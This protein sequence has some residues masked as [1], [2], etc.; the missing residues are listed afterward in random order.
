MPG[1]VTVYISLGHDWSKYIE[2]VVKDLEGDITDDAIKR[3]ENE[4]RRKITE[5]IP[6]DL[7]KSP[8]MEGEFEARQYDIVQSSITIEGV[9]EN[10]EAY[11]QAI[12]KLASYVKPG[13]Y[14]QILTCLGLT[15]YKYGDVKCCG[16]TLTE[17]DVSLG[18]KEAG[19]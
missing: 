11:Q 9:L 19:E 12:A 3:R 1:Y 14:M 10:R 18:F 15:W 6:C 13:G 16:F 17:E 7:H 8:W 4:I 5:I 2:Y